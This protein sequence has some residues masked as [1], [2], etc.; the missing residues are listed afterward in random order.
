MSG[1]THLYLLALFSFLV[2]SAVFANDAA[3]STPTNAGPPMAEQKPV[4]EVLH[5]HTIVDPFRWLE[6][7]GSPETQKWV[8]Q[9]LHYTRTILDPLPQRKEIN[10][11]LTEL[12]STGTISAPQPAGKYFFYTKRAG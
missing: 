8:S 2:V 1:G 11:R 5:G 4:Q 6:D 7:A 3:V 9:E 10:R 12:L